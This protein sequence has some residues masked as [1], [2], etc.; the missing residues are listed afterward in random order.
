MWL[1]AQQGRDMMKCT[2]AVGLMAA[3]GRDREARTVSG[4]AR[5][6]SPLALTQ[7]GDKERQSRT[8]KALCKAGI[9]F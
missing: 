8:P 7:G 5:R 3:L 6:L 1:P 2:M 9:I 4:W